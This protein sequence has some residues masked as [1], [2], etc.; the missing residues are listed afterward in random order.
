MGG[1][2]Q[3]SR[4]DWKTSEKW[5]GIFQIGKVWENHTKILQ[6]SGNF[7]EMLFIIFSDIKINQVFS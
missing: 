2:F 1:G 6:K 7:R 5:E 3:C 4:S